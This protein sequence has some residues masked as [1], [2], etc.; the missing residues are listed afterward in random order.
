MPVPSLA[1]AHTRHPLDIPDE[2]SED[3]PFA[4]PYRHH[5]YTE[6]PSVL[7]TQY[8]RLELEH[9]VR[10]IHQDALL[11]LLD[12][13][14]SCPEPLLFLMARECPAS[15]NILVRSERVHAVLQLFS[16]LRAN[17]SQTALK[18]SYKRNASN[19]RAVAKDLYTSSH[20]PLAYTQYR[21]LLSCLSCDK[22]A[23]MSPPQLHNHTVDLLEKLAVTCLHAGWWIDAER[24]AA[25]ALKY[26]PCSTRARL[27]LAT[28][29][30]GLQKLDLARAHFSLLPPAGEF[31]PAF[32]RWI[33]ARVA[34]QRV[35]LSR[36]EMEAKGQYDLKAMEKEPQDRVPEIMRS[37]GRWG[38]EE[39]PAGW[40]TTR[41]V[42]KGELLIVSRPVACAP[43]Y[44]AKEVPPPNANADVDMSGGG[45]AFTSRSNGQTL[46]N[47]SAYSKSRGFLTK[48]SAPMTARINTTLTSATRAAA[49]PSS[50]KPPN[51]PSKSSSIS[52]PSKHTVTT[53]TSSST[54]P[55][56]AA[57]S[58]TITPKPT[59]QLELEL[60]DTFALALRADDMF[61]LA[62]SNAEASFS[63][64]ERATYP[65][66]AM[67]AALASKPTPTPHAPAPPPVLTPPNAYLPNPSPSVRSL[68]P[69]LSAATPPTAHTA[70]DPPVLTLAL[71]ADTL[72]QQ[73]QIMP[74]TREKVRRAAARCV[75]AA[76]GV[77]DIVGEEVWA[78]AVVVCV[79]FAVVVGGED[80]AACASAGKKGGCA[81]W[82]GTKHAG[83]AVYL[84][85]LKLLS[86]ESGKANTEATFVGPYLFLRAAHDL[87]AGTLLNTDTFPATVHA[88]RLEHKRPR[89]T[90]L[91]KTQTPPS[92]NPDHEPPTTPVEVSKEGEVVDDSAGAGATA[93]G[94]EAHAVPIPLDDDDDDK[95]DASARSRS[96]RAP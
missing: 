38:V 80:R 32:P 6:H 12:Q 51:S 52:T 11:G 57:P 44:V 35:M 76:E 43:C 28:A 4:P 50:Y 47:G 31:P 20:F 70:E 29:H 26:E 72:T 30:M 96:D 42:V 21:A 63:T 15:D 66:K 33:E 78:A 87:P 36:M 14:L 46:T 53:T 65:P 41:S 60:D 89:V 13:V 81:G 5:S 18:Q 3:S 64:P 19:P 86:V 94:L 25:K 23:L 1:V 90:A 8:Q 92:S 40:R 79:C 24:H 83:H 9:E 75:R 16:Q 56:T 93:A 95:L 82:S 71:L 17:T 48:P 7:L 74:A 61:S 39:V 85:M 37:E 69:A 91:V 54:N 68:L 62:A 77:I 49:A 84:P 55:T 67:A 34:T 59:I 88:P 22:C 10:T 27:W 45:K 58:P 2:D 73:A